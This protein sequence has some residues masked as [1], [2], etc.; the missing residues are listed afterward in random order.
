MR[1]LWGDTWRRKSRRTQ[2]RFER[3]LIRAVHCFSSC[4][5]RC[6]TSRD[7]SC[8]ISASRSLSSLIAKTSFRRVRGN[9]AV[10]GFSSFNPHVIQV[11]GVSN[12]YYR[13]SSY[14]NGHFSHSVPLRRR[15][16]IIFV[17]IIAKRRTAVSAAAIT[18]RQTFSWINYTHQLHTAHRTKLNSTI[19]FPCKRIQ[20]L[21]IYNNNTTIIIFS[22]W[23]C[24]RSHTCSK[25][26]TRLSTL[27]SRRYT[28]RGVNRSWKRSIRFRIIISNSLVCVPY[29]FAF[30]MINSIIVRFCVPVTRII[31]CV[32]NMN[33]TSSCFYRTRVGVIVMTRLL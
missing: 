25:V 18:C 28:K 32:R 27:H 7:V 21:Y 31:I 1:F 5:H 14:S 12:I 23:M 20:Y 29:I 30:D 4:F 9:I 16:H 2:T 13:P 15:R 33:L 8:D 26:T 11:S 10:R 17:I 24:M 22:A 6:T 19:V 3:Y